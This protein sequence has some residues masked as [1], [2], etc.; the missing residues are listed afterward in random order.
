VLSTLL[1]QA[2]TAAALWAADDD[3]LAGLATMAA[4]ES[5]AAEAGSDVQLSWTKG[6]VSC[7]RDAAA[8]AAL[9]AEEEVPTGLRVDTELRWHVVRRLAVLG[10]IT[11]ADIDAELARD[12]TAAG[13]RHADYARAGRP[14]A[15]VKADVWQRAT[16]DLSLSNHQTGAL[17]AGFWQVEQVE[18]CRPYAER[19]FADIP[20]VWE[21]RT[22]QV[23]QTLA[24]AL[25]PGVV[26]D[27]DVLDR[28][29]A[30]LAG[31]LP[32]GLRRVVLERADDLRRAVAARRLSGG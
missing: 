14:D 4:A 23:A 32:P 5:R 19:Y 17:A 18:L 31:D 27:Q 9:L 10:A 7:S 30:F 29:D 12:S 11:A 22:P 28:T 16:Q 15:G 8:L 25:Y 24:N 2:R 20:A 3:L 21:A 26:V 1:M 13:E 6:W